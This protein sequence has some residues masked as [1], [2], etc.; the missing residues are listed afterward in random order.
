[1]TRTNGIRR[2]I[3]PIDPNSLIQMF[4]MSQTIAV[5]GCRQEEDETKKDAQG[6]GDKHVTQEEWGLLSSQI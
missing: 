6:Q 5:A 2:F 4:G 1:M 3:L